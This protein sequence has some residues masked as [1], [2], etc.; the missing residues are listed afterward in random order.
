MAFFDIPSIP[1]VDTGNDV[2]D[3]YG[4]AFVEGVENGL[5]GVLPRT[6]TRLNHGL[7]IRVKG[8]GIGAILNFNTS[9]STEVKEEFEITR[10]QSGTGIMHPNHLAIE[11]LSTRTIEVTRADLYLDLMERVFAGNYLDMLADQRYRFDVDEVWREPGGAIFGGASMW[12]YK[13]CVF[14]KLSRQNDASGDR[15]VRVSGTIR[16]TYRQRIQ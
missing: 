7:F 8:R 9:Q 13:G 16:W 14:E 2:L 3:R 4:N 10:S 11:R 15:V 1:P 12:R 5:Y 6:Q